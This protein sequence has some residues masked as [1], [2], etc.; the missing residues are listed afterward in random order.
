MFV[1]SWHVV[2][3]TGKEFVQRIELEIPRGGAGR[4]P[5]LCF[6]ERGRAGANEMDT[7]S[8]ASFDKP[9]AF[10]YA[11]MAGNRGRGDAERLGKHGDGAFAALP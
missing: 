8:A 9:G 6:L 1:L 5:R 2:R 11:Q 10:E 3:F 7:P 4:Q